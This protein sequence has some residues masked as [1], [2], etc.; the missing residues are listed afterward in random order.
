LIILVLA[1]FLLVYQSG[2]LVLTVY[3]GRFINY[4]LFPYSSSPPWD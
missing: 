3:P 4:N 2:M 1:P